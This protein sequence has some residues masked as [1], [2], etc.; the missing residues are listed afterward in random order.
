[1]YQA[2]VGIALS[3]LS[4]IDPTNDEYRESALQA[5][6]AVTETRADT[7]VTGWARVATDRLAALQ[8]RLAGESPPEE[9]AEPEAES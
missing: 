4:R 2:N 9:T 8:A 3:M 6:R 5:L 7:A 1:V